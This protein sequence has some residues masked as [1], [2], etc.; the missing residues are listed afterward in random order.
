[1]PM[2]YHLALERDW[3]ANA[4]GDYEISTLGHTLADVGFIHCSFAHQVDQIAELVYHGRDDVLLL[5]I[6]PGRLHAAIKVEDTFPHIYGPLN[7]DAVVSVTP[8]G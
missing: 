4:S 5:E 3:G 8:Y 2:L 6:D 1:M 7:R